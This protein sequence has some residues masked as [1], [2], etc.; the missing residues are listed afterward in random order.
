MVLSRDI[1][2]V[3]VE[4]E[5][6]ELSDYYSI[7]IIIIIYFVRHFLVVCFRCSTGDGERVLQCRHHKRRPS[8]TN[9]R[10][11]IQVFD[12]TQSKLIQVVCQVV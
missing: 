5:V 2:Q 3:K 4:E 10:V 11:R 8:K 1:S 12:F 7:I 6:Q 9:E